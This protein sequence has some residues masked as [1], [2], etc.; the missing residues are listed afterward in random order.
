MLEAGDVP[1]EGQGQRH[2]QSQAGQNDQS[3]V[4]GV[5]HLGKGGYDGRPQV[6]HHHEESYGGPNQVADD[7]ELDEKL[8]RIAKGV[9][10]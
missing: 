6:S 5:L 4:G 1:H 2:E 9:E 3:Q 8:S 7:P 10:C